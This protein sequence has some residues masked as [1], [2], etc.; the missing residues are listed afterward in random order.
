MEFN[1]RLNGLRRRMRQQSEREAHW[2]CTLV[3]HFPMRGRNARALR[4]QQL[5]APSEEELAQ[6]RAK[7]RKGLIQLTDK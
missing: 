2:I 6:I 4:V 3:N 7:Q 5:I 1:L